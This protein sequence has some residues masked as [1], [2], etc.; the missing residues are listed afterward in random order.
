MVVNTS[1][2]RNMK[3]IKPK[4]LVVL[5]NGKSLAK[6]P[7]HLYNV[8]TI[9][10]SQA[11][12]YWR[13][14]KWFPTYYVCLDK[15]INRTFA[16]E[17][18]DMI[19]NRSNNGIKRFFL[20]RNILQK[21]PKLKNMKCI[22]FIE[23]L[24]FS[25]VKGFSGDTQVTS[26]SFAVRYG[27]YLGYS[28]IYTLGIDAHYRPIDIKWI[29][30]ITNKEQRLKIDIKPDPDYFFDEYR[31]KG[32]FL[33]IPPKQRWNVRTNHLETFKKINKRF[34]KSGKPPKIINSNPLSML[35]KANILPFHEIPIEF[36]DWKRQKELIEKK[37][38]EKLKLKKDNLEKQTLEKQTLEKQ[39]LEKET[40]EKEKINKE[41]FEIVLDKENIQ[42]IL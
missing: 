25:H 4:S 18:K 11:F 30:S 36:L 7:F 22:D 3:R 27:I 34:N 5:G 37:Q 15:D 40:L 16:K 21:Y 31:K 9:G 13:K 32:D 41:N 19:K 29:K 26:G 1:P 8:D 14:I 24:N 35:N 42:I 10:M 28:R 38:L 17:I 33:H 2:V 6:Y 12:R 20:R 23:D 39:T